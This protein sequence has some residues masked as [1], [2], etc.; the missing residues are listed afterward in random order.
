LRGRGLG[1]RRSV[2]AG[3]GWASGI[4]SVSAGDD[5]S[6]STVAV[7]A[8]ACSAAA[9]EAAAAEGE[10]SAAEG[11]GYAAASAEERGASASAG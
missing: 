1:R 7:D 3:E 5:C 9:E 2:S 8:L 11:A 4:D 10:A 6:S